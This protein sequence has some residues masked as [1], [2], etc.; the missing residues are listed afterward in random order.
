MVNTQSLVNALNYS[1]FLFGKH[2]TL[3]IVLNFFYT[4]L[5]LNFTST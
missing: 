3:I 1:H 2:V 5:N 4:I